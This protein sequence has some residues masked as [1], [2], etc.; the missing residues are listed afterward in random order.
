MQTCKH[1]KCYHMPYTQICINASVANCTYL[2]HQIGNVKPKKPSRICTTLKMPR[3]GHFFGE[4]IRHYHTIEHHIVLA[5]I[6][7]V[8]PHVQMR[9]TCLQAFSELTKSNH[10]WMQARVKQVS[11][12]APPRICRISNGPAACTSFSQL[13][14][15]TLKM[16]SPRA[17]PS[18]WAT[19]R[20]LSCATAHGALQQPC[21][22]FIER[23]S[24]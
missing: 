24:P 7:L 21:K 16:F 17:W 23:C 20:F 1:A 3:P 9:G 10:S 13:W 22:L 4:L 11:L 12:S 2:Q 5:N 15:A 18:H 19:H 14:C 8:I 6:Q